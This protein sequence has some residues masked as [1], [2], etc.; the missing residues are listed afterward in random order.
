MVKRG[1][2]GEE[3]TDPEKVQKLPSLQMLELWSE[4]Q[5]LSTQQEKGKL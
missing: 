1:K 5:E 4:E 3:G 2:G